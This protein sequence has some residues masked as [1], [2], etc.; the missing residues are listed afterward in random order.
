[1]IIY[2]ACYWA[3]LPMPAELDFDIAKELLYEWLWPSLLP[4]LCMPCFTLKLA[5]YF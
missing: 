3:G 2:F 5:N 1:M 4:F